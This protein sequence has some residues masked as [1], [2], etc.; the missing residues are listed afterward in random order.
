[1]TSLPKSDGLHESFLEDLEHLKARSA[2]VSPPSRSM[3]RLP[4]LFRESVMVTDADLTS[5][6]PR[7]LV[8]IL[9]RMGGTNFVETTTGIGTT[10][11]MRLDAA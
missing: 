4:E 2:T 3:L 1:M 10:D 11:R 5:P 6:G 8:V 9:T 7:V